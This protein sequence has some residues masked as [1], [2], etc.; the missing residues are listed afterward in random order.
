MAIA[1]DEVAALTCDLVAIDSTNPDLVPGGAGEA[2][3]ARFVAGWLENAGL[4]VEVHELGPDRANVVAV[5]RGR[6]GGRSLM[7]NAHVDVVGAGGM[8]EPWSPRV[9]HDRLYGRG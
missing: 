8:A 9:E 3:I 1:Q 4:T 5:A 7:L 2:A 6:G